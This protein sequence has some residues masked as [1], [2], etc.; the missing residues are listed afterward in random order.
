MTG[1]FFLI[2]DLRGALA[3]AF[4]RKVYRL[5][6]NGGRSDP[7]ARPEE[8]RTPIIHIGHMPPK[9]S[10]PPGKEPAEDQPF[11]LIRPLDGEIRGESP[12]EHAVKIG[13]LC[14]LY[15]GEGAVIEAGYH[16]I[17]NMT[18]VVVTVLSARRLWGDDH[19]VQILPIKWVLGLQKEINIYEAGLHE[20]PFYGSVIIA[21]FYAAAVVQRAPAVVDVQEP[22]RRV[23]NG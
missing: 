7:G 12:R 16:D 17:M 23:A 1:T 4:E 6:H 20:H 18:D 21:E 19:W 9:R 8:F 10:F 14:C 22:R 15:T 13:I 3:E 11:I 5:A 2:D